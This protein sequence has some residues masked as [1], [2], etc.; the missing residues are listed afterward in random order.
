MSKA[1]DNP[2]T[3]YFLVAPVGAM[4]SHHSTL[5]FPNILCFYAF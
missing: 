1:S 3:Y 5:N 2:C 4:G